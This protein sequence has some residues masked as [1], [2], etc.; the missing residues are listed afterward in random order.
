MV[1]SFFF[2]TRHFFFGL[3]PVVLTSVFS[4]EFGP[5]LRFSL[6]PACRNAARRRAGTQSRKAAKLF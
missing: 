4:S 5:E 2:R 3:R 1:L 6:A